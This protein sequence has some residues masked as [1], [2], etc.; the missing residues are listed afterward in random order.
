MGY[1]PDLPRS[2]DRMVDNDR[3]GV[4]SISMKINKG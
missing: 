3:T 2:I 1:C 4:M